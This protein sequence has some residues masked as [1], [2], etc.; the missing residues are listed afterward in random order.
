M[1]SYVDS[2]LDPTGVSVRVSINKLYFVP[3]PD[4][5]RSRGPA[6]KRRRSGYRLVVY[7]GRAL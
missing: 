3:K 5:G 7:P 4:N 2:F 6:Q 1:K